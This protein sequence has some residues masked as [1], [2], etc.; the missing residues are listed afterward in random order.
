MLHYPARNHIVYCA[1][2]PFDDSHIKQHQEPYDEA[3]SHNNTSSIDLL[4][5]QGNGLKNNGRE[6]SSVISAL[7][8]ERS[9]SRW[10]A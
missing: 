6:Q 4:V 1:F 5:H 7:P 10:L 9:K 2:D 8:K 3:V